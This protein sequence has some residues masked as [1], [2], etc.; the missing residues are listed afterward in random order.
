LAASIKQRFGDETTLTQGSSGQFDVGVDG[1]LVFS[2]KATGR[3]PAGDE[4]EERIEALG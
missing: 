4:V 2:K 1:T 3:F